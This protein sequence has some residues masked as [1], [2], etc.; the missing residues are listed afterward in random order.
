MIRPTLVFL[1]TED[2]YFW[3]HRVDLA[4]A[5]LAA[6]FEV[7]LASRFTAHRARIEAAGIRCI[8]LP[9]VRSLRNPFS[10]LRLMFAI[11]RT[12]ARTSPTIVHTVALKPILLSALAVVRCPRTQFCHAV[13]G[14]GYLFISREPAARIGRSVVVPLLRWLF[15]RRC[16][17]LIL[18]NRDDR[19]LF[20]RN[21]IGNPARTTV[22]PGAGVDT[23]K[24]APSELPIDAAPLVILPARMLRDKGVLE[25]VDAARRVR[26][27]GL[28]ARFALVGSA[29]A[30]NPAALD[31]QQLARLCSDGLVEWWRHREDMPA[32]YAQAAIVC[33]P[34]YREG[35]PKVLLEAAASGRPLVATDVPGCREICRDGDTGLLVP[36]RDAPAL[37]AAITTLLEDRALAAQYGANARALVEREFST[38]IINRHTLEFYRRIAGTAGLQLA[39]ARD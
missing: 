25:F 34:S 27:R 6:G 24:F 39:A 29:D 28:A 14:L 10:E 18:Q 13:T 3:S 33:L 23:L 30:E 20:A 36:P 31:Q 17:W 26:A 8:E 22:I 35:F 1:V 15:A 16:C 21:A 12:I 32:V 37:A 4:R 11:A 5:A 38:A 7:A 19:S 2:W 9:F